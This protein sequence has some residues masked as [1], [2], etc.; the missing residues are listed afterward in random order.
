MRKDNRATHETEGLFKLKQVPG[1]GMCVVHGCR[2]PHVPA[3][4]SLCHKHHQQRWRVKNR[5][6]GVYACLRDRAKRRK[7]EFTISYDYFLGL[8][9]ATAF[10]DTHPEDRGEWL[11]LDRRDPTKGYVPGNLRVITHREN[12]VKGNRERHLPEVVQALLDRKR[13]AFLRET[14]PE[15][16]F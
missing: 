15:C 13:A 14:A 1:P 9:D 11:T 8:T 5:K 12:T 2:N 10:W 16:P 4:A 6:G 7:I 3:K